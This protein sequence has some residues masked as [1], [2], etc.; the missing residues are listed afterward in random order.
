MII[1]CCYCESKVDAEV[2]ASHEENGP[3]EWLWLQAKI[4]LLKCPVCNF[5]LV[6]SQDLIRTESN[7][8]EYD[9]ATR[10]WPKP[11]KS[12]DSSIPQ[13]VKK[14]LEEANL[15]YKAK[16]YDA[17]AVMCG[18]ALESIC[19]EYK[20]KETALIG[21]LKKLLKNG[22]IDKKIYEWS[23]ALRLHRNIGAHAGENAITQVDSLDLLEFTSAICDYVFV[24]TKKFEN[25]KKRKKPARITADGP[26]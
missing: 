9:V 19:F 26:T 11:R 23:E 10:V 25:F 4:S 1:E 22:V 20:I 7:Q 8:Y 12:L 13:T 2:L 5:A 17:C 6:A 21:G 3:E 24:L 18:K 16:A 14:A 15:C